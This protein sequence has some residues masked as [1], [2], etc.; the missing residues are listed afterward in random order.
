MLNI[1]LI[2]ENMRRSSSDLVS[3]L[4]L[5][6]VV[7]FAIISSSSLVLLFLGVA[8]MSAHR[9]V[10]RMVGRPWWT[11]DGRRAL[12]AGAGGFERGAAGGGMAPVVSAGWVGAIGCG[13]PVAIWG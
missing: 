3:L 12:A 8:W 1:V 2:S 7:I 13:V 5:K 10:V 9:G 6:M 4:S 11:A